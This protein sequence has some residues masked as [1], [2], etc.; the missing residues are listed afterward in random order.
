MQV[1]ELIRCLQKLSVTGHEEVRVVRMGHDNPYTEDFGV[2]L[3]KYNELGEI[4]DADDNSG[5]DVILIG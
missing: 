1:C 2:Q 3:G 5:E 4:L